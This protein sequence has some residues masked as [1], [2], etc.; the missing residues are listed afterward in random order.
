MKTIKSEPLFKR[1]IIVIMISMLILFNLF[2]IFQYNNLKKIYTEQNNINK[3]LVGELVNK[4]PEEE[5]EIIK[6]VEKQE[7]KYLQMGEKTLAKYGYNDDY[8]MSD[9]VVFKKHLSNFMTTDLIC[10]GLVIVL[11]LSVVI[12]SVRYIFNRLLKVNK[13]I[14]NIINYN[15]IYDEEFIEDGIF[16]NIYCDLNKLSKALNMKI[17][18]LGDEKESIK[19]LV[20]DISHQLKTPL[21]SLKL[22]N[23]LL[24]EEEL[25][26]EERIEF[27]QTND[28]SIDKLHNLIDSLVN[29]SRLEASMINIKREKKSIKNTIDKA[30]E[31]IKAVAK[32]KNINIIIDDFEDEIIP[33]DSKWTEES[34]FNVLHNGVKYTLENGEVRISVSD[35]I[36]FIRIDIVDNGIGIDECNYNNIFKR[37]YRDEEVE[38][39]EGAGVGLYLSRKILESQGGNIIVSS[40]KNIGSKFSLFLSKV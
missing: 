29:I 10:L 18:N 14:E 3:S 1:I 15:Y 6:A 39:I 37:F 19:E 5:T 35:I 31:N 17:N 24:L 38:H 13:D 27:L 9:N 34:I 33:H 30:V 21:A 11:L 4:Y 2:I 23:T 26:E 12:Y 36:N 32:Q 40:Q 7:S 28:I 20:T 25:D 22:Y 8:S 16:N